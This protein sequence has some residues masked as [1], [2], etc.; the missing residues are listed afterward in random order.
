[1]DSH[2]SYQ[3]S[4]DA[5]VTTALVTSNS[6]W[7]SISSN[8]DGKDFAGNG[9]DILAYIGPVAAFTSVPELSTWAMMLLGLGGLGFTG[10]RKARGRGSSPPGS[11]IR[12]E[13]VPNRQNRLEGFS[14]GGES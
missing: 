13:R 9:V 2:D 7:S 4:F 3:I 8:G 12:L 14:R 10:Y 11:I 5:T 6:T 1:M